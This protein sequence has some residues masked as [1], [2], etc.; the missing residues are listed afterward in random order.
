MEKFTTLTSVATPFPAVNVDTDVI[1]PARFLKTVKRSGLGAGAFYGLRF[2]DD[3]SEKPD[4]VFNQPRY[5]GAEILI[6]GANFGC[7]S[8][9]EHAPWALADLGYRAIVAP[10]FADIFYSNCFKNGILCITLAQE[11]VD[12]LMADAETGE[13]T[14]DLAAQTI[15][16]PNGETIAFDYPAEMKQA[17]LDGLDEIGRTLR[18]EEAI[19]AYEERRRLAEPWLFG[20]H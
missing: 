2:N 1:I 14:I 9:R 20:A 3:G 8:S 4:A 17:L 7:G 15:A 5:K 13:L 10:S 6:T 12:R 18:S 19:T 16:R 11:D